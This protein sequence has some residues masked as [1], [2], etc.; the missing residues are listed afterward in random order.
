MG[1]CVYAMVAVFPKRVKPEQLAVIKEFFKEAYKA[2][3]YTGESEE[4]KEKFPL[5]CEYLGKSDG[6]M[7]SGLISFGSEEDLERLIIVRGTLL[8]YSAEVWH[9]ADWDLLAEY[10]KKKFGAKEVLLTNEEDGSTDIV[11]HL[12]LEW[13][14]KELAKKYRKLR[15]QVASIKEELQTLYNSC[16]EGQT[17]VWDCSTDEG[18]E[19]FIAMAE[20]VEKIAKTLK[21]KIKE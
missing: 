12:I 6:R 5:V 13:E 7:L 14:A 16:I 19:G 20:G 1:E 2:H 9:F 4:F 3:E 11:N 10:M 17:G 18:R 15:R 21:L 8:T